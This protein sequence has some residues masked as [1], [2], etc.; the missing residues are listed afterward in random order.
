M[1]L[2]ILS[3]IEDIVR[4]AIAQRAQAPKPSDEVTGPKRPAGPVRLQTPS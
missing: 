1:E 3:A 2:H 4:L